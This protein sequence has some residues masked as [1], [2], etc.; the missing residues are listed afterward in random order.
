MRSRRISS[1]VAACALATSLAGT[2]A[3]A[4]A[5]TETD[6]CI[7]PLVYCVCIAAAKALSPVIPPES[8]DCN[9]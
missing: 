8:W 6:A 4:Q 9:P 5:G 3:P 2:A 1:L 7:R